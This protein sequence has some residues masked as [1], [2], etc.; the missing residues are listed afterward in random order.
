MSIFNTIFKKNVALL[1]SSQLI[2]TMG[3][4]M[5]TTALSLFV[6]K[7]TGDALKFA[8]VLAVAIVPRLFGPF[9]GVVTDRKNRKRMLI[10]LDII[11]GA[12]T[13]CFAA[14][15][16]FFGGMT[17]ICVYL[18]VLALSAL[19]TFYDP[20]V[21][22]IIPEIVDRDSLEVTNSASSFISNIAY[23]A[24]AAIAGVMYM[25]SGLFA[26]MVVNVLSFFVAAAFEAFIRYKAA[27]ELHMAAQEP[28]LKSMKEGIVA[29][30]RNKELTLI[31][32]ISIIA[33]LV[34]YPICNVGIPFIMKRVLFVNDFMF[35]ISQAMLFI[36][37]VIGS[38]LA[39]FVLKRVD[40]KRMLTWIMIINSV[41]IVSLAALTAFGVVTLDKLL[42]FLLTNLGALLI[43]A[44]FVLGGIAISTALQKLVPIQLLGRVSGV[45]TSFSLMA[46]P[47]GQI[48]FGLVTNALSPQIAL[49]AFAGMS[50]VTGLVAFILYKPL[51]ENKAASGDGPRA[52]AG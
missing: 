29:L 17:I 20:T 18:L 26:V 15:H 51:L 9:T 47:L 5:Q 22:A 16:E 42:L 34:I 49:L 37:P 24:A 1:L 50:F 48:L 27:P 39:L 33:N 40:Y 10:V 19:Q 4:I 35:G 41:L 23:I 44:A 12:T 46:I 3:S 36:G 38:L 8:S 21:S 14:W 13:L 2:S 45:D 25:K 52:S 43:V 31:V 32:V 7:L 30:F 6:L 28:V 11:A